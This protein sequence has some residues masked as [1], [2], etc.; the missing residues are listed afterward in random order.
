MYNNILCRSK[1]Y[2]RNEESINS[3]QFEYNNCSILQIITAL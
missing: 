3:S 1:N 2:N